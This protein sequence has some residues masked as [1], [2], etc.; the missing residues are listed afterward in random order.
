HISGLAE[1]TYT[2]A[3][4]QVNGLV[5]ATDYN[6]PTT[7]SSANLFFVPVSAFV[8]TPF[9]CL[10]A[11]N[12][13]GT[14]AFAQLAVDGAPLALNSISGASVGIG[15]LPNAAYKLDVNG[16]INIGAGTSTAAY[17]CHGSAGKTVTIPYAKSDVGTVITYGTMT[18]VGGILV[19]NT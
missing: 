1:S 17:Y 13:G 18:F 5:R 2:N 9:G 15:Y 7:G 6:T 11:Y 16:H 12:D 10:R 3:M 19:A 8:A 14:G 4:L